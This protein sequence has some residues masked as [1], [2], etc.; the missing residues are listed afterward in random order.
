M[1]RKKK[2]TE[3]EVPSLNGKASSLKERYAAHIL[4]L[5]TAVEAEDED[6][7]MKELHTMVHDRDDAMWKQLRK[8]T[9]DLQGA[10]E[11]FQFD[12]RLVDLA[13]K[14]MPDAKNR[15]DHVMRMTDEAAHRTMDLVEQSGPLA[16]RT[17]KEASE[18][19]TVWRKFTARH[20]EAEEFSQLL[21]RMEYFLK[22][23]QADSE[24]VRSNLAEVLM[25]Q[26]YQDLSGQIIRGVIKLVNEVEQALGGLV[27]IALSETEREQIHN[28]DEFRHSRGHGPVVPGVEHGEV[29]G[30]QTDVDALL[31]NLGM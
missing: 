21:Q 14:E 24:V 22:A 4:S 11:R 29:V 15:L 23:A 8:L 25:T 13:E 27:N 26:G 5:S 6:A 10:L 3:A 30:G 2:P 1:A 18:L 28:N 12:S 17:A 16:G 20:I 19:A 7:F 9:T 31:S